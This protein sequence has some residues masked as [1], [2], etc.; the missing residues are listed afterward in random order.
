MNKNV[1]KL[2]EVA[3]KRKEQAKPLKKDLV[4]ECIRENLKLTEK[5]YKDLI[6]NINNIETA[7]DNILSALS[8]A[9]DMN[10]KK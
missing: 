8:I 2:K 6:V 1:E 5:S 3:N 10:K 9:L 7:V 4:V